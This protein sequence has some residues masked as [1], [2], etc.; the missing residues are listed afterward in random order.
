M[1]VIPASA[2]TDCVKHD[3]LNENLIAGK[4]WVNGCVHC[5]MHLL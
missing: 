2:F 3:L 4:A 1:H 5:F